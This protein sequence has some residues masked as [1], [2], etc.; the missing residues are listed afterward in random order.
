MC[1]QRWPCRFSPLESYA[2]KQRYSR[3]AEAD[4]YRALYKLPLWRHPTRGLRAQQ[5]AKQPLCERH[6]RRGEIVAADTVNHRTPHK[7]DMALFSDPA[8]LESTCAACHSGLIQSEERR[9]HVIGCDAG[10]RPIDP[11]HPWNRR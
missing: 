5:L 3:S 2:L 7:G 9:G 10:G 4:A 1:G 8:N 11:T 6:Q